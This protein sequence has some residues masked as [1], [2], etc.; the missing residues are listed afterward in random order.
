MDEAAEL[1]PGVIPPPLVDAWEGILLVPVIG[2]LD[3]ARAERITESIL[4]RVSQAQ[5]AIVILSVG[6]IAR[7]D[8]DVA[9]RL[10]RT[11]KAIQLMGAEGLVTGIRPDV[12]LAL[13]ELGADLRGV[14]SFS[15]L[16]EGLHYAFKRTGWRVER[17][18]H[19]ERRRPRLQPLR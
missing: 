6:G 18:A 11:V 7:V 9:N 8:L 4:E 12:A 13:I 3:S 1:N 16:H 5:I 17:V 19:Q 14:V 15:S 10:V 2:H